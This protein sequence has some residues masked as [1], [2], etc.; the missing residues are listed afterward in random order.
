M[1]FIRQTLEN[2]SKRRAADP[3][4]YRV[5]SVEDVKIGRLPGGDAETAIA[6]F[7]EVPLR[8][9]DARPWQP[10]EPFAPPQARAQLAEDGVRG[11]GVIGRYLKGEDAA[12]RQLRQQMIEE[13]T[14][15]LDPVK[16]GV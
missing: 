2:R 11:L 13:S 10:I 5:L 12:F 14:V 8:F 6:K 16:A 4:E 15:V 9:V 1:L 7:V 3:F